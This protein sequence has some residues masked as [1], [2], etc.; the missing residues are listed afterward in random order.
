MLS[1]QF[2]DVNYVTF[3]VY[4]IDTY[5]VVQGQ[6]VWDETAGLRK[7]FEELKRRV[8]EMQRLSNV[9]VKIQPL[10]DATREMYSQR[11]LGSKRVRDS[12]DELDAMLGI[13][14]WTAIGTA[15]GTASATTGAVVLSLLTAGLATPL[16]VAATI[17]G[18]VV[19]G[20]AT[21]AGV[22]YMR[23]KMKKNSLLHET[24]KWIHEDRPRCKQLL[25]LIADFDEYWQE[26]EAD[27]SSRSAMDAQF[28]QFGIDAK[29]L[30]DC[31]EKVLELG[32]RWRT[33]GFGLRSEESIKRAE[34][35]IRTSLQEHQYDRQYLSA[36]TLF[37][38]LENIGAIGYDVT[39]LKKSKPPIRELVRIIA[40][41]LEADA[42]PARK[43]A[44]QSWRIPGS[45]SY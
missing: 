39:Y 14:M 25:E 19:V 11:R 3:A 4:S 37:L 32:K 28:R 30:R 35:I 31:V 34:D 9:Y 17:G 40:D 23:K 22:Q 36:V 41:G 26:M 10:V 12:A 15:V 2:A 24:N 38:D 5:I 29:E 18:A 16:L 45:L 13:L 27:F 21:G 8:N 33:Y 42:L 6:D 1:H 20:G 43:M 7:R 44:K